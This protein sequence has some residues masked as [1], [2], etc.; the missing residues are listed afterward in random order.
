MSTVTYVPTPFFF[1]FFLSHVLRLCATLWVMTDLL[2]VLYVHFLAWHEAPYSI[3]VSALSRH[4][5]FMAF[6]L[7]LLI[8]A[9]FTD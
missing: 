4:T 2:S 5:S 7:P 8:P 3:T 9:S 6:G 1:L